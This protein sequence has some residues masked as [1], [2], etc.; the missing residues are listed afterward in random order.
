L[1]AHIVFYR[2]QKGFDSIQRQVLLD[3]L[4]SIN[5]P[6]ISLKAILG[7]YTQ[8][9]ILIKFNSKLSRLAE[10]DK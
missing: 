10:I 7:I 8:N 3:I 6:E 5:I 2:L 9:K 1:E 4:K